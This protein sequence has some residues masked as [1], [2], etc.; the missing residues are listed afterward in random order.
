MFGIFIAQQSTT[1][2][3]IKK[4]IEIIENDA[5]NDIDYIF[6]DQSN[7]Y[8]NNLKDNLDLPEKKIVKFINFRNSLLKIYSPNLFVKLL[9][10]VFINLKF[11]QI[12][13][14]ADFL[15]FSPGGAVEGEFAR[16]I[17]KN[18]GKIF[19]IEGGLPFDFV[20]EKKTISSQ[21]DK[22]LKLVKKIPLKRF[23]VNPRK[24]P[25]VLTD[26]FFVGGELSKLMH[27]EIGYDT[28]KIIS[29]G[30]PRNEKIVSLSKDYGY[31]FDNVEK[32]YFIC[33]GYEFHNMHEESKNMINEMQE[34]SL[35]AMS[36]NLRF[37]ARL[38]PRQTTN[39]IQEISKIE[40][41]VMLP[42]TENFDQ[43]ISDNTIVLTKY[44]NLAFESLLLQIP[45]F[46][47]KS[48]KLYFAKKEW[49]DEELCIESPEELEDLIKN[50]EDVK[51]T[52]FFHYSSKMFSAK[53]KE[54]AK[55]IYSLILEDKK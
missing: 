48:P 49:P 51:K 6:I 44:S 52:N 24:D 47:Y 1:Y 42:P 29:D 31:K 53:T 25:L 50:I 37:I 13:K 7:L 11:S 46:F 38:H 2:N 34:I 41:L 20:K 36:H 28:K 9:L 45:T 14:K 30:V 15:V 16:Q 5:E 55:N 32:L 10:I 18:K 21:N 40:S 27:E 4:I 54:S 8:L 19:Q 22:F 17:K 35:I 26:Y 33:G 23:K 39:E 3:N 43:Q 12:I